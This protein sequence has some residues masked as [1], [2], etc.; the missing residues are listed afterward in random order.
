VAAQLNTGKRPSTAHD[1]ARPAKRHDDA[2]GLVLEQLIVGVLLFT[3]LL[4]LLP[5]TLV[6]FSFASLLHWG[7]LCVQVGVAATAAAL[8]V[9]PTY[10]IVHRHWKP[11]AYPSGIWFEALPSPL[12]SDHDHLGTATM[13]EMQYLRMKNIP[14]GVAFL[15][16]PCWAEIRSAVRIPDFQRLTSLLHDW[17]TAII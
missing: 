3:P 13:H 16:D 10:S 1:G 17:S 4:L 15:L 5:T 7:Y 12:A 11:A 8:R 6:F 2:D 14:C 9:N